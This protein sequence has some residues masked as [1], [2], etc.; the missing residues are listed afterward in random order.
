[1]RSILA[2]AACTVVYLGAYAQAAQSDQDH[3][4][5]HPDA[6][7]APAYAPK[8]APAKTKD[9]TTKPKAAAASPA[10]AGV[11]RGTAG[12]D[13]QKMHDEMHKPGGMHDQM[14]GKESAMMQGGAMGAMGGM[15]A[16]SAAG[17]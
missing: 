1:M 10:S 7:S 2:L 4:V 12:G 8:Q 9:T 17:K 15:P 11:G 3:A 16:A 14:H 13:M 5:H 6:A